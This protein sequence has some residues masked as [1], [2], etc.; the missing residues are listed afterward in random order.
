MKRQ[1]RRIKPGPAAALVALAGLIT[2]VWGCGGSDPAGPSDPD[3][4]AAYTVRGWERFEDDDFDGALSDFDAALDLTPQHGPAL[5][6][7]GWTLLVRAA[8]RTRMQ[9]ALAVFTAAMSAGEDGGDVL[10]GKA[11]ARLGSGESTTAAADAQ[12]A[13]VAAPGFVFAHRTSFD[14]NDL[15][16]L[17]AIAKSSAGDLDGALAAADLIAP[18][19]IAS[20]SPA[21]W[22]VGGVTYP[23]YACA[24]LARLQQL[25]DAHAG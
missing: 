1:G 23:S 10:A 12:A 22:V 18:S 13:L 25:S 15:L 11:C 16:L 8:S 20:G 2:L 21:T 5:T 14:S 6:G 7:R 17:L 19:G 9:E 3:T 24:V 4:P